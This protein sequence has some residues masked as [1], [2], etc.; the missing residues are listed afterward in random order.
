MNGKTHKIR[1]RLAAIVLGATAAAFV[2]PA[3]NAGDRIVDDWFRDA[4]IGT[5]YAPSTSDRIVD[6]WFR[7]S[8][9]AQ[10][11]PTLRPMSNLNYLYKRSVA[12]NDLHHSGQTAQVG[13]VSQVS[14][15]DA[16]DWGNLELG[17]VAAACG[18]LLLVALGIGA[19]QVR[20]TRHRLGSA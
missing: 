10:A 19:R 16:F 12:L 9:P 13:G 20:H 3:A 1:R 2:A 5:A 15:S 18:L 14:T 4:P 17:L 11:M 7:D 6:D 8:S